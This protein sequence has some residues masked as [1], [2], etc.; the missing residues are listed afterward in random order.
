MEW[1]FLFAS[2]YLYH[3]VRLFFG[4]HRFVIHDLC[5]LFV[6][7]TYVLLSEDEKNPAMTTTAFFRRS[8]ILSQ[9]GFHFYHKVTD[10]SGYSQSISLLA[11]NLIT[12]PQFIRRSLHFSWYKQVPIQRLFFYKIEARSL[13][14]EVKWSSRFQGS[15]PTFFF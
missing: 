15:C 7:L 5:Y 9:Q 1:R 13:L 2:V 8:F 10:E 6:Y 3:K 4:S 11:H 12:A 14:D